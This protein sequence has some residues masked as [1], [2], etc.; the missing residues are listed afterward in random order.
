MRAGGPELPGIHEGVIDAV[1]PERGH[2]AIGGVALDQRVEGQ[3]GA[4]LQHDAI[5]FEAH[6][7][8][9]DPPEDVP[10][11][12]GL[13]PRAPGRRIRP[14]RPE[15]LHRGIERARGLRGEGEGEAQQHDEVRVEAIEGPV[16]VEAGQ[17]AVGAEQAGGRLD[18]A[19]RRE[20]V[21]QRG[22]DP[23]GIRARSRQ[24][25][26]R[27]EGEARAGAQHQAARGGGGP[28]RRQ[29]AEPGRAGETRGGH[30]DAAP[31]GTGM[32]DRAHAAARCGTTRR[33]RLRATTCGTHCPGSWMI[34]TQSMHWKHSG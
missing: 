15:R 33:P 3:C 13:G 5:R 10:E 14:D 20:P 12:H 19:H 2:H 1:R 32:F 24:R 9:A 16:A 25:H 34:V 21:R 17:G 6:P 31:G 8:P 4:G 27:A 23:G 30:E 26:G 22:F 11:G 18:G 29:A 7:A 28:E